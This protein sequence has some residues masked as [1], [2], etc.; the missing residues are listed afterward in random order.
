M[1]QVWEAAGLP[2]RWAG[3]VRGRGQGFSGAP[4]PGYAGA[5]AGNTPG[6]GESAGRHYG[7]AGAARSGSAGGAGSRLTGNRNRN[8]GRG[9]PGPPPSARG[10]RRYLRPSPP[11]GVS[12]GSRPRS[13]SA[14]C[15]RTAGRHGLSRRPAGKR[16]RAAGSGA[17]RGLGA[18]GS[19]A[20]KG[21]GAA[22]SAAGA[23]QYWGEPR[24]DGMGLRC[25]RGGGSAAAPLALQ[26]GRVTAGD[27]DGGAGG[28]GWAG[29]WLP[30]A[31]RAASRSPL[32]SSDLQHLRCPRKRE[33]LEHRPAGGELP[34][35]ASCW[36][37]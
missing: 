34:A 11:P 5:T 24:R 17:G 26:L 30:S 2:S 31:T 13:A 8:L 33:A 20:G 3:E 27:R 1:H 28:C 25:R 21:L 6:R 18:A 12:R 10:G 32:E 7:N 9:R 29:F 16:G 19:G 15:Q 23:R 37:L 14:G 4:S 35:A 22:G 36:F